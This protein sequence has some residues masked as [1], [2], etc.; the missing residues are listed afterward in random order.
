[1]TTAKRHPRAMFIGTCRMHDPAKWLKDAERLIIR[2]TPH[3][4]HTPTQ[5]LQF[6]RHMAGDL[7]YRPETMHLVSDY[8]AAEIFA[9]GITRDEL[10][11]RLEH[12]TNLWKSFDVFVIEICALREFVATLGSTMLTVNTFAQRDQEKYADQIAQEARA[13]LSVPVLPIEMQRLTAGAA[14]RLMIEIKTAL[15]G[16]PIIWVSHQR[17]PDLPQYDVANAVRNA[18]AATLK[19]GAEHLGDRFFDPTEV[20]REMGAEA[21]FQKDGT[22]IDHMTPE[23][24][25]M[26]AARY[27]QMILEDT[28][29]R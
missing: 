16:R 6:I 20:A 2:T 8:A 12:I 3:R 15:E 7:Q 9:N 17:P 11:K 10:L 29:R 25:K 18:L 26:M 22:D 21:F 14:Q 24:A 5:T 13:N 27:H 4:I 23:A 28:G 19:A 1:M